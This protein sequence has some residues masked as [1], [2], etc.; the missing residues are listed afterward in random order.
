M[1]TRRRHLGRVAAA[2]PGAQRLR[3]G[4]LP[5]VL[6]QPADR[7]RRPHRG[8]AV[9]RQRGHRARDRRAPD[10]DPA[11][12]RLAAPRRSPSPRCWP[13][14]TATS[15]PT[16]T[17]C[18]SP[19]ST[20]TGELRGATGVPDRTIALTRARRG[21]RRAS[22]SSSSPTCRPAPGRSRR[23]DRARRALPRSRYGFLVA[24]LNR[25]RPLDDDYRAFL[26]LVAG[27]IAAGVASA[28]A[29]EAERQRAEALAELDRAKTAFFTNVSHELRTPLTLLL[30]PAEDALGRRAGRR[31][32]AARRGHHRNA[33]RLLKLV[34][35]L[36]DFSRLESGRVSAAY[37][38]VDLAALHG[39]AG[40]HVRLRGRARRA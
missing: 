8:H 1:R 31:A 36:L 18:R 3:R 17:T 25:Y 34:N 24:G 38:P 15:A 6:L 5:H 37:E 26:D 12:P 33:Q 9:R 30:G 39:R 22:S 4:D 35:T 13:P 7:R 29:Y 23:L 40:E 16:R 10:G 11:R 32:A 2:V 20:S 19:S 21:R 27:Q 14:P 28:R